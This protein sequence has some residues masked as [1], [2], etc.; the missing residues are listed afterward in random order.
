MAFGWKI[1][2]PL[3]LVITFITAA[4]IVLAEVLGSRV[5]FWAIPFVSTLV[6]FFTVAM[7]FRELRRLP[8]E[9]A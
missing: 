8:Y 4:G 3:S 2:L 6:G 5:Y 9:R 1:L 7:V